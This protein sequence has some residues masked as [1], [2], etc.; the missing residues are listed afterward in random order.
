MTVHNQSFRIM[1]G[2]AINAYKKNATLNKA[3]RFFIKLH[4]VNSNLQKDIKVFKEIITFDCDAITNS[5]TPCVYPAEHNQLKKRLIFLET[6]ALLKAY[7]F[8]ERSKNAGLVKAIF[9]S[10]ILILSFA[11]ALV[12]GNTLLCIFLKKTVFNLV[13]KASAYTGFLMPVKSVL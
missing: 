10:F 6:T 9:I 5:K 1:P 11:R 13:E 2:I 4:I 3:F 7:K 8:E 12:Y